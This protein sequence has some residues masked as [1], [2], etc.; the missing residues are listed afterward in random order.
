MRAPAASFRSPNAHRSGSSE[1]LLCSECLRSLPCWFC[2]SV[3]AQNRRKKQCTADT[4]M[5]R[6][7]KPFRFLS[8]AE[9]L[10]LTDPAK[11]TYVEDA[12]VHLRDP[13]NTGRPYVHG[14]P[15]APYGREGGRA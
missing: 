11:L 8:F 12:L 7:T 5:G 1:S 4:D 10:R 13:Q 3:S 15:H 9:F 2:G 6:K 14:C